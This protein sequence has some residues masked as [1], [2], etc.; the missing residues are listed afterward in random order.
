MSQVIWKNDAGRK[1]LESWYS[2]FA[3]RI[4]VPVETREVATRLGP[5]HVLMAGN[6]AGPTLVCLHAMRTGAAHLLSELGPLL[7]KFHIVAPDLPGQSV[8][9]PQ[10][11]L[12]LHDRSYAEWLGDVLDGLTIQ[13]AHLL[14]VSW[15]GFVARQFAS[16]APARVQSLTLLVPAGIVNGSTWRGLMRMA[17]P[18]LRYK[19]A[20]TDANL[21]RLLAPLLTSW[22]DH[23]VRFI[24]DSMDDMVFDMRIPPLATDEELRRLTMPALVL[25]GEEDMS[26]PGVPLVE[27]V[28]TLMP[29]VDAE[30]IARC[31]HCPPTDEPFQQWFATRVT[32]HVA[33]AS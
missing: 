6:E 27:R 2:R 8:R 29:S 20:R 5:S 7:E 4:A 19:L 9:G 23:W 30:V 13:R 26:F 31:K 32:A 16:T 11:R 33:R 24:A 21:K 10:V 3:D 25:A 12:P 14:G 22:E 28:S 17:G 15:G 18:M 1:R